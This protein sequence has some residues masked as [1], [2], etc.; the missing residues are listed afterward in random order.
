LEKKQS[1]TVERRLLKEEEK[2]WS[3]VEVP[4]ALADRLSQLNKTDLNAIRML[5]GIRGASSLKKQELI[6]ALV[7]H[8]PTVL[9]VL[10]VRMDE[11]R[12]KLL[13]KAAANGGYI[14]ASLEDYQ[15][16]YF[17]D[18]GLLF[19]GTY[20]GKEVVVM[21]QEVLEAFHAIDASSLRGEL[22][23][24]T[25]WIKLTQG[26]LFYYGVLKLA[27][28]EQFIEQYT[29]AA[30]HMR[31]FLPVVE[32]A[33]KYYQEIQI[34]ESCFAHYSVMNPEL[35]LQEQGMRANV[36][37][38][39]FT[40]SDLLF[41]GE[42]NFTDRNS[43]FRAFA[44][45]ISKNNSVSRAEAENLVEEC[46]YGIQIGKSPNEL[47]SFLQTHLSMN[48]M[49]TV[50]AY[51]DHIVILHNNTRQWCIKGHTPNELSKE[52][53]R[54]EP[55]RSSA[56]NKVVDI[57]SARKIGRNEPCLCGSGKKYKKCCME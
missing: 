30:P 13:K 18:R 6:E 21:P 31:E 45:F 16:D 11:D 38:K 39:P 29:G 33:V 15:L 40:K 8:I 41:A 36:T 53:K 14:S 9:P 10:L 44:E 56:D 26:L 46:V 19:T 47:L 25:E 2:R 43:Y 52:H 1:R 22:H 5:T 12:F 51:A 28:L 35:V 50:R 7:K 34:H 32:D 24:N 49:D 57:T 27:D 55:D 37:F 23:Q 17:Q 4:L 3:P 48:D 54:T 42:P 20:Q